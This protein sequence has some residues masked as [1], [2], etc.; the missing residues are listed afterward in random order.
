MLSVRGSPPLSMSRFRSTLLESRISKAAVIRMQK[1]FVSMMIILPS[2]FTLRPS[3]PFYQHRIKKIRT[4]RG[5]DVCGWRRAAGLLSV[6]WSPPP[7]MSSFRSTL[8]ESWISNVGGD[9]NAENLCLPL[10]R[11]RGG[12]GGENR[13]DRCPARGFYGER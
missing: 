7:S 3:P 2:T 5:I 13:R 10:S 12:G 4:G 9:K 1:T 11:L 8:I 6:R